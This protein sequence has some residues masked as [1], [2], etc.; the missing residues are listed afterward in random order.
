M[1][2]WLF[3]QIFI[4]RKGFGVGRKGQTSAI[5]LSSLIFVGL[6]S[7]LL[8]F[9]LMSLPRETG[10]FPGLRL[11]A[12]GKPHCLANILT[13]DTC[14]ME[15][16]VMECVMDCVLGDCGNNENIGLMPTSTRMSD[17]QIV[18]LTPAS[19]RMMVGQI[20]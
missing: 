18:G 12:F 2:P 8:R 14:F 6:S 1:S 11:R 10:Y 13:V 7:M 17:G 15:K 4:F 20:D 19:T 3:D 5:R 16:C 9:N